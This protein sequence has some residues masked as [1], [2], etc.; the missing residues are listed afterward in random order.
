MNQLHPVIAQ[1]IY[2]FITPPPVS[3]DREMMATIQGFQRCGHATPR[4]EK[5]TERFYYTLGVVDLACDIEYEAAC[6][7]ST[8]YRGG[9]KMEPDEPE[10]AELCAAYVRDIDISQILSEDQIAE[11][12]EAF[13]CQERE[14]WDE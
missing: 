13:L 8:E 14:G 1:S 6:E 12:E 7:G 3:H 11:I 10:S 5:G 2:P 4:P 9:P